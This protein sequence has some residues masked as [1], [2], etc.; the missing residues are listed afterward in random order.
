M[1]QD[2]IAIIEQIIAN[3]IFTAEKHTTKAEEVAWNIITESIG[4]YYTPPSALLGFDVAAVEPDVP[5][6]SDTIVGYEA[7]L[8]KI[9]NLLSNQLAGFFN[10]YYPLS[11]DSYDEANAWI[12]NQIT[13]GGSW[14][15]AAS[16]RVA[17]GRWGH[18]RAPGT[19]CPRRRSCQTPAPT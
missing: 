13:N 15:S 7:Q 3:A 9:V 17:A 11:A 19:P 1:A 6:V 5:D 4:Y 8:D 12:L 2:P 18:S 10:T 16:A 14:A